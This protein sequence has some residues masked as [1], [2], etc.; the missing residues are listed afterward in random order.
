MFFWPCRMHMRCW[1]P[2]AHTAWYWRSVRPERRLVWTRWEC[3]DVSLV[4]FRRRT[5]GARPPAWAAAGMPTPG[6][7]DNNL[8]YCYYLQQIEWINR[9]N[10]DCLK[11]F[12]CM[13]GCRKADTWS[14]GQQ[15]VILS[16]F[17]YLPGKQY[18][19]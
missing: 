13:G 17:F 16:L 19:I 7:R 10:P 15:S 9:E 12:V 5:T 11:N 1:P 8:W 14:K 18:F 3:P 4:R 6:A 2:R